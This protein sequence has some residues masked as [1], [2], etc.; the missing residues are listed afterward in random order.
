MFSD[1]YHGLL[2]CLSAQDRPLT[3]LPYTPSLDANFLDRSVDP[4]VDFYQ[5]ACGGWK[6]LNPIPADQARWDVY[7]KLRDENKRFL[8]GIL[9]EAAKPAPDRTAEPA[10]DR[11]LLRRLHGRGGD[12]KGRR[13]AAAD[14]AWTRSPRCKSAA[15]LP[16]L[17][18]R[19]HLRSG[20]SRELALRLRLQPGLRRLQPRHRLRR[21]RR[22]GPARPRLLRQDRRQVAGDP[23]QRYV[24]HVAAHVRAAGRR[25]GA[26]RA[27]SRRPSWPSR[28]RWPRRRSRASS[29]AIP[30][31]CST[32]CHAR[33]ARRR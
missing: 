32:S 7:G 8:W 14:A 25:A 33:A 15:D 30:T 16:P 13:R 23:R 26:A 2:T 29:G 22:P 12:R 27:R 1:Y 19:L 20:A 5:F 6:K 11:R 9:E 31:S 18:A 10:E 17:L 21:R 4:C 28:P 24:E 3:T